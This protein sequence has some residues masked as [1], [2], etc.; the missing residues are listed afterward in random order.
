MRSDLSNTGDKFIP[1]LPLRFSYLHSHCIESSHGM[2]FCTMLYR[3]AQKSALNSGDTVSAIRGSRN[4]ERSI[5]EK[6]FHS[7]TIQENHSM[8]RALACTEVHVNGDD[9][10]AACPAVGCVGSRGG[11]EWVGRAGSQLRALPRSGGRVRAQSSRR[12]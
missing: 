6:R 8:F 1:H 4:G 10:S 11:P 3:M 12:W 2:Y 7:D 9:L 5:I